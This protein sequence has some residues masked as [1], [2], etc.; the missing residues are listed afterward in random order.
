EAN[1]AN[2]TVFP[3]A[4]YPNLTN[5]DLSKNNFGF[6]I[7]KFVG[8]EGLVSI[9]MEQSGLSGYVAKDI[10][11]N[12]PNLDTL[13]LYGNHL[14]SIPEDIFL[15]QQLSTHSFDEQT[16]TYPPTTIK[17]GENLEVFV[18]FIYQA[19]DF[20]APSSANLIVIRDNGNVL[21][22]PAYPTYEGSYMYKIETA[23][24][25]PGEHLLEI[26]LGYNSGEYTGWYDFPVTITE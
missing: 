9:N 20:I 17:Q 22:E 11:M 24:L 5:V 10:W 7:P 18:P 4:N 8:M 3:D 1:G 16:A 13:L 15:S 23:G 26:S 14:I 21:Y 12:M 25:Q 2:I 6:H 19:L